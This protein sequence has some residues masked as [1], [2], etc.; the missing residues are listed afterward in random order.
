[1]SKMSVK[2]LE[3]AVSSGFAKGMDLL[4]DKADQNRAN[5]EREKTSRKP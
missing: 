4:A 5:E 2:A 3:E 1:M